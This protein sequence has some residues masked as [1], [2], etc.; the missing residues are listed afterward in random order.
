MNKSAIIYLLFFILVFY[1][2]MQI[3]IETNN[4]EYIKESYSLFFRRRK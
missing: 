1:Y 4:A 3:R 2:V